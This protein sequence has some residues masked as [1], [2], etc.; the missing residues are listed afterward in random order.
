VDGISSLTNPAVFS[1]SPPNI[2]HIV[3][4]N[5]IGGTMQLFGTDFGRNVAEM[6]I[7][8]YGGDCGS[9]ECTDV[10]LD[11]DEE[12]KLLCQFNYAGKFGETRDV[13]FHG[14]QSSDRFTFTYGVDTGE[15]VGLPTG[16]QLRVVE[17][18]NKSYTIG[19]T[20][21]ITPTA[22]VL[23]TVAYLGAV[24]VDSRCQ[25]ARETL[26]FPAGYNGSQ[27][28]TLYTTDNF[29]DEGTDAVAYECKLQLRVDS[30]DPQYTSSPTRLIEVKVVNND[31]ADATLWTIDV[32][33][34]AS[35]Y[36]V[37][38]LNFFLDEGASK[39]YRFGLRTAPRFDVV[40]HLNIAVV[41]PGNVPAVEVEP[42]S[43]RFT[44]QN[45]TLTPDV[46]LLAVAD[47]MDHDLTQFKIYHTIVTADNEFF[48]KATAQP[49][50]IALEVLDD[51][52]AG[53]ELGSATNIAMRESGSRQE[54][55]VLKLRSE[56]LFA[57]DIF[58]DIPPSSNIAL[59][60]GS[61]SPIHIPKESWDSVDETVYVRAL[62]GA[63]PG[64]VPLRLRVVSK[65]PKYNS[66]AAGLEIDAIVQSTLAP[67]PGKPVVARGRT[68]E[69]IVVSWT[70]D[71][72]LQF[73]VQWSQ[74]GDTFDTMESVVTGMKH[75]RVN[76]S[77]PVTLHM[78]YVR[79]RAAPDGF[80]STVSSGWLVASECNFN[81]QYLS[82]FGKFGN[83]KCV[84]CPA[85]SS[86][87]GSDVTWREV[88]PLFGWWRNEL[89][90][91]EQASNF[92]RCTFPPA[93]L[94]APNAFYK[95][96][97]VG[98]T[99]DY[100]PSMLDHNESCN[101]GAL[102]GYATACDRREDGRCR[103]CATCMPGF[104][105]ADGSMQCLKC[106]P[107]EANKALLTAGVV[108]VL[109][110]L[111]FMIVDHM[112]SGG[113]IDLPNM[114]QVI[115]INYFQLTYMIAGANVP[116]PEPLRILFDIQGAIST[117][118]EHLLNP[119]CELT[120]VSAAE[121]VYSK[122]LAY[123]FVLPGLLVC[124]KAFWYGMSR[125]QGRPFRYRGANERSPSH[126]DGSVATIVFVMYLMYPTL[127]RQAFSLLVCT[128][129]NGELYLEADLQEQCYT[130]RHLVYVLL[131]TVSQILV[132]VLGIPLQG[133]FA[134]N[135]ARKRRRKMH[136]SIALFRDGMLYS[137]FGPRRWYWGAIVAIRKALI[138]LTTS[139][140]F[141]AGQEI[142]WLILFLAMSIIANMFYQPYLGVKGILE[143]EAFG[144]QRFDSL[145][146][147]V[148]L[149]T[150]WSG[151]YFNISTR[152]S[153]D[154]QDWCLAVL[155]VV[156]CVN[157]SFFIFCIYQFREKYFSARDFV[158]WRCCPCLKEK[159]QVRRLNRH[160]TERRSSVQMN[161]LTYRR[162]FVVSQDFQNPMLDPKKLEAQIERRS[163]YERK[164]E[165]NS[166]QRA[167]SIKISS[168]R[169]TRSKSHANRSLR[170]LRMA[171]QRSVREQAESVTSGKKPEE[172]PAV[173][174][175]IKKEV[176]NAKAL[177]N[178]REENTQLKTRAEAAEAAIKTLKAQVHQFQADLQA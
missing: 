99:A 81:T 20:E 73:E 161:P 138:V 136:L 6:S 29:V 137:T 25:L 9:L 16:D 17:G 32:V 134:A 57:V 89:W 111:A 129:V 109:G 126:K 54:I 52:T 88:R 15:L 18:R 132:H 56:P 156:V 22:D 157:A 144:L 71:E 58:I 176:S 30:T 90:T 61:T 26:L 148:L 143:I 104:R 165:I 172:G 7:L 38:F 124:T 97:Y 11:M 147:F 150:A 60:D 159:G 119:A 50:L 177:A 160:R 127:C 2:T 162:S 170:L 69:E 35:D 37:K 28:L 115:V 47:S 158:I 82:T 27:L 121:V 142:H 118:G 96:Q 4:P 53:I 8:V 106:P 55:V 3:P 122:Q 86:C 59:A 135:R 91:E 166:M 163:Q 167:R 131:L 63:P 87:E 48:L 92:S 133:L 107:G 10:T 40:V 65:D 51:D 117:I 102:Y 45:W 33:T 140:L 139:L 72:A 149:F 76:V 108:V 19:L 116:W 100:D 13:I 77:L 105:R 68:P 141:D 101:D 31:I 75:L 12:G 1:Y 5:T 173:E 110:V 94:G 49:L 80:W 41:S 83:W 168:M 42:A 114:K 64:I 153:E 36:A 113:K 145:S 169:R 112:V 128:E 23:V 14:D 66:T 146:L 174:M 21:G 78:V 24:A 46:R 123:M 62:A 171:K 74:S 39:Q 151:T 79:V 70:F 178:L 175:V 85:G 155:I 98:R 95:G 43:L 120:Y 164:D 44:A 67:A 103:L 93:C 84:E 154:S 130:G 152:C 34:K 125:I